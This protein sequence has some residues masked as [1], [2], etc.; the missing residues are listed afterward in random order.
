MFS[1]SPLFCFLNS[2]HVSVNDIVADNPACATGPPI[3]L[4]WDHK[5]QKV[6]PIEEFEAAKSVRDMRRGEY[7]SFRLSAGKRI[8]LLES[9]GYDYKDIVQV[10]RVV[11]RD[12]LLREQTIHGLRFYR[13]EETAESVRSLLRHPV[14]V[15]R[16][17]A[18]EVVVAKDFVSSTTKT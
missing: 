8:E 16:S 10:V 5:P 2:K 6:T 17:R 15:C 12:Q 18:K 3:S 1:Y 7:Y 13:I 9:L 14:L 4:A 11:Q